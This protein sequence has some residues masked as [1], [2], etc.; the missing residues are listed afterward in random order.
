MLKSAD[1]SAVVFDMDG[2]VLDT[3]AGY[4]L[5]WRQAAGAMGYEL[6]EHAWRSLSGLHYAELK[7]KLITWYG[8][9][10]NLEEFN[11]TAGRFWREQVN[12]HGIEVKHGFRELLEVITEQ[13]IPF[14]LA[15]NSLEGNARECLDLA[16]LKDIFS[17]IIAR[18]HVQHAKPE[19]DIFLKAAALLHV[20]IN[21]CLVIED[22]HA[23]IE[24]AS[25]AGA[26]S[27]FIPS[28]FPV[29]PLTADLCDLLMN[30]LAQL[31]DAMRA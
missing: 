20:E 1:F 31:A 28:V 26:F 16:G 21:R 25:R 6:P 29:N 8:P 9:G 13:K 4:I 12:S 5:A 17:T 24:A 30:D 11:Q 15:T 2:L 27:V 10:F 18:N 22:S 23:G 19:P 3:E 14:C 7:Q